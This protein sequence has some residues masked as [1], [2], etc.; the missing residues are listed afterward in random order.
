MCP[1]ASRKT[2]EENENPSV[3]NP[4][5]FYSP[6]LETE[7]EMNANSSADFIVLDGM[8]YLKFLKGLILMG[9]TR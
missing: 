9:G 3:A 1:L 4:P 8:S 7:K 5:F 2:E 6:D